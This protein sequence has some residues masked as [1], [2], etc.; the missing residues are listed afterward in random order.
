[1][2]F[3]LGGYW[4][5]VP[6]DSALFP[7]PA[8]FFLRQGKF[9]VETFVTRLVS[10]WLYWGSCL[11]TASSGSISLI[12]ESQLRTPSLIFGHLHYSRSLSCPQDDPIPPHPIANFYSFS[13]HLAIP[14]VPS[15]TWSWPLPSVPSPV[16]LKSRVLIVKCSLRRLVISEQPVALIIWET[17]T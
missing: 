12:C 6:S 8:F 4:L 13:C 14:A 17:T 5:A 7:V 1:M 11:A 10:L 16:L 2:G 15:H 9:W 3:K